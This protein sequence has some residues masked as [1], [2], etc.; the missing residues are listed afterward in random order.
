MDSEV[1]AYNNLSTLE[2]D[3]MIRSSKSLK[4]E[5]EK[6]KK[7]ESHDTRETNMIVL[8][9]IDHAN[10]QWGDHHGSFRRN[11]LGRGMLS[12]L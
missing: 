6:K 8:I 12:S 3:G 9:T 11:V 1:H 4:K 7:A 10:F 2:V 5:G